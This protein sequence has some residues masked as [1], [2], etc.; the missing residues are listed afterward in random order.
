VI[1]RQMGLIKR[2]GRSLSPAAQQLYDLLAEMRAVR[3][4]RKATAAK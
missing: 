1:T 2:R 4:G 3:P